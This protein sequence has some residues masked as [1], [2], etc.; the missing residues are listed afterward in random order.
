M[1]E[2]WQFVY[3][4]KS[5]K[6]YTAEIDVV[7]SKEAFDLWHLKGRGEF[8]T[9]VSRLNGHTEK[10]LPGLANKFTDLALVVMAP[11]KSEFGWPLLFPAGS[12]TEEVLGEW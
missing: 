3:F 10:R 4:K 7:V 9:E 2:K 1:K 8:F 5:G 6:F 12:L 11:E